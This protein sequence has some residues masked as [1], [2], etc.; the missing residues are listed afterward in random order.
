MIRS[1]LLWQT[2]APCVDGGRWLSLMGARRCKRAQ[3]VGRVSV[4]NTTTMIVP[5]KEAPDGCNTGQENPGARISRHRRQIIDRVGRSEC[6]AWR[7]LPPLST[8]KFT[9]ICE[10]TEGPE[11]LAGCLGQGPQRLTPS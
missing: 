7:V 9:V 11:A 2:F 5:K 6:L 10:R 8:N 3:D 4:G 1:A